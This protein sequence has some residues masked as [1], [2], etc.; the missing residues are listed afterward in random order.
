MDSRIVY[1]RAGTQ[2]HLQSM[3]VIGCGQGSGTGY[4]HMQDTLA[5][6]IRLTT[7]SSYPWGIRTQGSETPT[8]IR[9]AKEEVLSAGFR[10]GKDS[11]CIHPPFPRAFVRLS[12]SAELTKLTLFTVHIWG[13]CG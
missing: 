11:V 3:T 6:G 4:P 10:L 8:L 13:V 9:T 5:L 7:S 12:S 2:A 1:T